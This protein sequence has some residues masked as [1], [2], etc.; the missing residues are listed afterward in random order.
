[1]FLSFIP[2]PSQGFGRCPALVPAILH[3]LTGVT[4]HGKL[5]GAREHAIGK[6]SCVHAYTAAL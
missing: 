1:M 3:K 5:S 6:P 4:V 2:A